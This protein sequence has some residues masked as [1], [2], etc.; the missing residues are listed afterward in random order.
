[1]SSLS[2][3]THQPLANPV[4][5]QT[6]SPAQATTTTAAAVNAALKPGKPPLARSTLGDESD[7]ANPNQGTTMNSF[8]DNVS[9][10]GMTGEVSVKVPLCHRPTLN[11]LGPDLSINLEYNSTSPSSLE[12]MLSPYCM[13]FFPVIQ[14]LDQCLEYSDWDLD[15]PAIIPT[16]NACSGTVWSLRFQGQTFQA[17]TNSDDMTPD[18][19]D[20]YYAKALENGN[21]LKIDYANGKD[22]TG[23]ATVTTPDGTQYQI[24]ANFNSYFLVSSITKPNGNYLKFQYV[25]P[26][27]DG[28]HKQVVAGSITVVDNHDNQV[29]S[30]VAAYPQQGDMQGNYVPIV[31]ANFSHPDAAASA[32]TYDVFAQ[33]Q[34]QENNITAIA[35]TGNA[36]YPDTPYQYQYTSVPV[37]TNTPIT[38][39][40]LSKVTYPTG[41]YTTF[42]WLTNGYIVNYGVEHITPHD[43]DNIY[44]KFQYSFA[45]V[46]SQAFYDC[47]GG[48]F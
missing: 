13:T 44:H 41:A 27:L 25:L 28:I 33:Y 12:Q 20:F 45:P 32:N 24:T 14:L 6:A 7:N 19:T 29:F 26:Y 42:D 15:L 8:A 9:V 4:D 35:S 2:N 17:N 30:M 22:I 47:N 39:T 43:K 48:Q 23:G 31:Y 11:G 37:P 18:K 3:D 5:Q 46:S 21:E 16:W 36:A 40:K 38:Y 1:M 34:S 10:N